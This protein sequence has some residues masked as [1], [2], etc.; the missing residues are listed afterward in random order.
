MSKVC[1]NCGRANH[2][3]AALCKRC[4]QALS[5]ALVLEDSR[6]RVACPW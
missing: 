4:H 3:K 6:A 1:L 2:A 5:H